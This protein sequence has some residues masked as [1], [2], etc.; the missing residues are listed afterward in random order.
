MKTKNV[1]QIIAIK[2]EPKE[3]YHLL[4]DSELHT[5]LAGS[6]TVIG[7]NAGDP[8]SV[9]EGGI[10]GFNL[11]L[12]P[13]KKIVQAWREDGWPKGHYSIAVFDLE[14]TDGGTKLIF[15][16]YGV[17]DDDYKNISEGWKTYYWA[18]MKDMFKAK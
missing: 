11:A 3:V 14:K 7:P 16:Q 6:K 8:F 15:D 17:P 9:W 18:P 2:A 1:H 4:M 12:D 10:N 13:D 5:K